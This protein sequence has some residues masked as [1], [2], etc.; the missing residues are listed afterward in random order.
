MIKVKEFMK[1][2]EICLKSDEYNPNK[3]RIYFERSQE[4]NLI[5]IGIV[6]IED[7]QRYEMA[8][9]LDRKEIEKL[10]DWL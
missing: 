7:N 9:F 5:S 4:Y 10:K 6:K 2:Y 1:K 8:L 3:E